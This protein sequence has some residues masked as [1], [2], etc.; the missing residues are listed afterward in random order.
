LDKFSPSGSA[1][2]RWV[3]GCPQDQLGLLK[4]RQLTKVPQE[5][6]ERQI[7]WQIRFADAPKHPQV[8]LEQREQTLGPILVHVPAWSC[9]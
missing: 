9:T 7:A 5:L 3:Y 8:G 6:E 4:R 2:N 1:R